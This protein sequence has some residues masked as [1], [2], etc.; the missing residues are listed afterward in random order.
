MNLGVDR[1]IVVSRVI[2][3]HRSLVFE[4]FTDANH[5]GK[6][7][8][9]NGFSITT[10]HFD[11]T[12]GGTWEFVM[13]GPDGTD[14]TNSIQFEEIQPPERIVVLHGA[15]ADDPNAFTSIITLSDA[16]GGTEVRLRSVFQT[17]E[18]RDT[19]I[20]EYHAIEGAEQT[21]AHLADYL[22]AERL[23]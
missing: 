10:S 17:K 8:G 14:Y 2:D 16:E 22:D 11:F 18:Q 15:R 12:P 3:G 4:A 9:P 20:A 19:A 5:L 1:E 21:L 23:T 13:H 7:W 6:W